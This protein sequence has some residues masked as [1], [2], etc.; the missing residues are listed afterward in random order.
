MKQAKDKLDLELRSN[1]TSAIGEKP[2]KK[3]IGKRRSL[4]PKVKKAKA[5]KGNKNSKQ[6]KDYKI[7]KT[8]NLSILT[9]NLDFLPWDE[10]EQDDSENPQREILIRALREARENLYLLDIQFLLLQLT[11]NDL[12]EEIIRGFD[13]LKDLPVEVSTDASSEG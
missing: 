7:E 3:F 4:R 12:E 1:A 13:C 10:I 2:I 5:S 11:K 9:R 8:A 6:E